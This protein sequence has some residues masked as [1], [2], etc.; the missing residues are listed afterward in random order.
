LH[1][2]GVGL[3]ATGGEVGEFTKA[4]ELFLEFLIRLSKMQI[5]AKED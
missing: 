2:G 4:V 3:V 5:I 1:G